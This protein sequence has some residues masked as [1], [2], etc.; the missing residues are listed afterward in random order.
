[1]RRLEGK[2]AL[3]TGATSGIGLATARLFLAEGARLIVTGRNL[4]RLTRTQDELGS[5][6]LVVQSDAANM[7]DVDAL[8]LLAEQHFGKLDILFLNACFGLTVPFEKITEEDF[9]EIVNVTLKS[10]FFTIQKALPILSGNS[11]IV[12][13]TSI[14]NC[15]GTP[16][17]SLYGACKAGLRSLVRS[18]SLILADRGVRVNAVSPG[19]TLTGGFK[20]LDLPPEVLEQVI[21]TI[22]QDCPS[23]RLGTEEEIANAVLFLSSDESSYIT[24]QEIV[25]DGGYTQICLP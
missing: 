4:E 24:G 6:V 21:K 14:T 13:A 25:V 7:N 18:L 3:I 11:K 19:P 10:D 1:M 8:L 15:R 9:N 23:K 5:D 20:A 17:A 16:L 2:T 22:A 12:V